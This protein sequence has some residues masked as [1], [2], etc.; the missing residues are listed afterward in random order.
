MVE[1]SEAQ[2][3]VCVARDSI[4]YL[5]DRKKNG[6][7]KKIKNTQGKSSSYQIKTIP[8]F[9]IQEKPFLLMRDDKNFYLI[10]LV[11]NSV[12][13]GEQCFTLFPATYENQ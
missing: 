2:F 4:I 6:V 1:Y 9:N 13:Q 11:Q 8:G 7:I 12:A 5:I 3:A 10:S